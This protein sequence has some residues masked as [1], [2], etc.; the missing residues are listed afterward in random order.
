M[1][2]SGGMGSVHLAEDTWLGR[3]V[4]VKLLRGLPMR[5]D[6]E[7]SRRFLREGRAMAQ[8]NHPC[9]LVIHDMGIND[10]QPYIV[11]E[12]LD[13]VDLETLVE[14]HG[15]LDPELARAL[16]V[17]MFAGLAAVHQA[18]LLHRD[19]KPANVRVT[20]TG[21]VVLQDFGLARAA[22][23]EQESLITAPGQ[24]VGTPRYMAPEVIRGEPSTPA[25]DLYSAGMC[26]RFMLTGE[27]PF[28]DSVDIGEVIARA[29]D[30]DLYSLIDALGDG[31]PLGL[32]SVVENL[33]TASPLDR[34]QSAEEALRLLGPVRNID[35][36]DFS[37]L[38]KVFDQVP[39][40]PTGGLVQVQSL[41]REL[42]NGAGFEPPPPALA[43]VPS[44]GVTQ[45]FPAAGP[46]ARAEPT[47]KF[48]TDRLSLSPRTREILLSLT[49]VQ[50]APSRLRVAV[51]LVLRGDHE[52]ATRMLTDI[53]RVCSPALGPTDPTILACQFWQ[54]V[55]LTRTGASAEALALLA[56][57]S[58]AT[59]EKA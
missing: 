12:L 21:R 43:G 28:A 51:N 14:E 31:V 41:T 11:M 6:S 10:G 47:V 25:A 9:V 46:S 36:E 55:C 48:S 42:A 23:L 5:E 37:D 27:E 40:P 15:Q 20:G 16:A 7:A 19:V 58:D 8:I 53:E 17:R 32:V 29:L 22:G 57:V 18:G 56:R 4:A 2:G 44:P 34:P 38:V 54:A 59:E 26:L 49:T 45:P 30:G 13:G 39:E 1:I 52:E 24:L 3:R 50:N 35:R 33:V